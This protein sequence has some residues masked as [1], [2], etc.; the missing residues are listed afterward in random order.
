[1]FN[2]AMVSRMTAKASC[3]NLT[4]RG[5]VIGGVDITLI[6][7]VFGNK[8]VNIDRPS[9]LDLN[10]LYLLILNN[11]VLILGD[12]VATNHVV[13]GDDLASF[14]IDVLLFQPVARFSVDPIETHFFAERRGWIK[15]YGARDQRKPKV[16]LPVRTRRHWILLEQYGTD[17]IVAK[18]LANA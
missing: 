5:N 14:G 7:L 16:A 1:M 8:L 11:H 3:T 9:A 13:P 2:F 17:Q 12:L 18:N 10:G 15:R 6:D 4:V